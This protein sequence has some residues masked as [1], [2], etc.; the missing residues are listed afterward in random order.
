MDRSPMNAKSELFTKLALFAAFVATVY[1]ANWAIGRYGFIPVG[2]GLEAPAGV[3]FA[4]LAFGLRDGL[5]ETAGTHWR[6]WVGAAIGLGALLSY[7]LA[8]PVV[9]PNGAVL[10]TAGEVARASAIAFGLSELADATAYEVLRRRSRSKALAVSNVIGSVL[11]SMLF[12]WLAFGSLNHLQGQVLGK[13][14][15]VA[16]ALLAVWV[17]RHNG[18]GSAGSSAE[19]RRVERGDS[20]YPSVEKPRRSRV[21]FLSGAATSPAC[22][23]ARFF[24]GE[25]GIRRC[26]F[27]HVEVRA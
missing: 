11:D 25:D 14:Y 16:P 24:A 22:S 1:G 27:C 5:R 18:R 3:L 21:R 7:A 20:R 17:V 23:H 15:M 19:E 6:W 8:D 13:L 2:F 12:L 10:A 26:A 9:L 4:G